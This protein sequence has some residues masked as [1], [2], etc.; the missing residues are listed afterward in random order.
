MIGRATTPRCICTF[1]E[2]VAVA[3]DIFS[4]LADVVVDDGWSNIAP[5]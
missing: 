2:D 4:T 3:V 5:I 1:C